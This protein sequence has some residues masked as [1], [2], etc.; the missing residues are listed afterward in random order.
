VTLDPGESRTYNAYR[1][2]T[3]TVGNGGGVRIKFNGKPLPQ[4]QKGEPQKLNLPG[5]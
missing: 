3:G 2:I 4:G 1:S 5:N